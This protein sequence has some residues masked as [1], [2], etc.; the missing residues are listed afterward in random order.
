MSKMALPAVISLIVAVALLSSC[1]TSPPPPA[2]PVNDPLRI[3]NPKAAFTVTLQAEREPL[4]SGDAP[5]LGL[6]AT[7]A[8][9][10][11]LYFINASGNAGQLLT[12]YPV[13]A[14]E[15]IHFPPTANKKLRSALKPPPDAKT[16]ILVVTRQPLNLLGRRDI[17]NVKKPRT[18][19]A[20]LNLSGPQLVNRLR[21]VL[22]RWPPPAW[23]ADSV[24]LPQRLEVGARL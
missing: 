16:F 1:A 15:P 14:N 21:D 6:Q 18:V 12:N 3:G 13:Q 22:R 7:A 23:N 5:Q 11:N 19:I 10:M 24:Q 4:P 8:G 9:Y 17:K 20:E 2:A